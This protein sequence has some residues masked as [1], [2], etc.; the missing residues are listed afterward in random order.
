MGV[1]GLIQQVMVAITPAL[2]V[3]E[4]EVAKVGIKSLHNKDSEE[5]S[6]GCEMCWQQWVRTNES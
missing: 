4:E 5:S 2:K 3:K 1:G 6:R